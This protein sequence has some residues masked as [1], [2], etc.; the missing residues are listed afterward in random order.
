VFP[1]GDDD[2]KLKEALVATASLTIRSRSAI[3]CK[4]LKRYL[5]ESEGVFHLYDRVVF[6][7]GL[8]PDGTKAT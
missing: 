1:L 4:P 2:R 3:Y 5:T 6:H 7:G 8:L